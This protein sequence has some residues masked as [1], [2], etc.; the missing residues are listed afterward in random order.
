MLLAVAAA[1]G[2]PNGSGHDCRS[3]T[4]RRSGGAQ[5][6]RQSA[7]PGPLG[8]AELMQDLNRS[9]GR[10]DDPTGTRDASM[11][12][13]SPTSA[14]CPIT[15]P[16]GRPSRSERAFRRISAVRLTLRASGLGPMV[17]HH[18]QPLFLQRH[19]RA[20]GRLR[21]GLHRVG[22]PGV[23]LLLFTGARPSSGGACI[24]TFPHHITH[25][26]G[27]IAIISRRGLGHGSSVPEAR[28]HAVSVPSLGHDMSSRR[29]ADRAWRRRVHVV[30]TFLRL[31]MHRPSVT[32]PCAHADVWPPPDHADDRKEVFT[33]P[34]RGDHRRRGRVLVRVAARVKGAKCLSPAQSS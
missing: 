24:L 6:C 22:Y 8:P 31:G 9:C 3:L 23:V 21:V 4:D 10:G 33:I 11:T 13:S 1:G 26:R 12:S 32:V 25:Q 28:P 29:H 16:T 14:R 5:P 20:G 19:A 30:E 27:Q 2:H 34:R 15:S 17:P 7:C 18:A